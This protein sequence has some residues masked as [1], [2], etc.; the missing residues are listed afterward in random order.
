MIFRSMPTM[1]ALL[2]AGSL[3]ATSAAYARGGFASENPFAAEHI[4]ALPP[5]IQR[6]LSARAKACGNK[7]A[8]AHY[9]SVTI[10]AN[11]E[12][13]LSLH[14][15]EFSCRARTTLCQGDLCLHEVYLRSRGKH[16]LVFSVHA[17]DLK[18]VKVNGAIGLEVTGGSARGRYRWSGGRFAKVSTRKE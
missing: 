6:K 12:Q 7:A 8:A 13:F 11:G 16:R 14:F 2:L 9:F 1:S 10:G 3:S 4:E 15:E 17:R 18:M 5:E